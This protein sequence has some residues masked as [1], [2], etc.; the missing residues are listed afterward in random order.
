MMPVDALHGRSIRADDACHIPY[1]L[2]FPEQPRG[3]SVPQNVRRYVWAK[4]SGIGA[5]MAA[6]VVMAMASWTEC[7]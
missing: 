6:R 2:A 3:A 4:A 1:R 5:V 7:R